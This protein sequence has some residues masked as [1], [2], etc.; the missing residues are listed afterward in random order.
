[1]SVMDSEIIC[2]EIHFVQDKKYSEHH[3]HLQNSVILT[4][5]QIVLK[6]MKP[7]EE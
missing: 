3:Q 4:V 7:V 1:M 2:F 6:C 5:V